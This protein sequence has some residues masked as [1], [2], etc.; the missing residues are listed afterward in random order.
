MNLP[1]WI[2]VSRLLGLPFILYL[3]ASP[4]EAN[5]WLAVGIFLLAA[6]TDWL[7]GYLGA[8]RF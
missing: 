4:T 7:D 3:L 6:G 2:T 8:V 5:L 1:T